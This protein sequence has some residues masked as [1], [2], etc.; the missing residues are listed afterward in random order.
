MNV[1]MCMLSCETLPAERLIHLA[2]VCCAL[3]RRTFVILFPLGTFLL[4]YTVLETAAVNGQ[5]LCTDGE[6]S[7]PSPVGLAGGPTIHRGAPWSQETI[8]LHD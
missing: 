8:P 2:W 5:S 7:P 4:M 3:L 1:C 6:P